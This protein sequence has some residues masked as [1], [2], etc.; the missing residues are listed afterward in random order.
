MFEFKQRFLFSLFSV[1][2]SQ[3]RDLRA[4]GHKFVHVMYPKKSSA[5]LRDCE[6][7]ISDDTIT[8]YIKNVPHL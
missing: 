5:L 2:G 7:I 1:C 4:I 3:L 6:S 8:D